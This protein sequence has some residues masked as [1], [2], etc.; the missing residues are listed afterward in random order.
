MNDPAQGR[1][2][3]FGLGYSARTLARRL[4][5][6]GWHVLGTAR[7]AGTCAGLQAAGIEAL[8][9]DGTAPL[10]PAKHP[11][12]SVTHVLSSVPPDVR[13]D[14][15]LR[16]HAEDLAGLSGLRWVGYLSTTGVY[17][18]RSGEWVDEDSTLRPTGMRGRRR[19]EAERAWLALGE[20]AGLAVH[21]FRLAGIYGPGRSA[22]E[23]LRQ[24]RAKRIRKPGQVFSRIHVDDLAETL[25]RSMAA[26]KAGRIYN[27]CDDK[28]AAPEDVVTFAARLLGMPPPPLVAFEDAD[29]SDMARSFYADNKRV[30]NDRIKRELGVVLRYADYEAGLNAILA[31]SLGN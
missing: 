3:C 7:T 9:F 23:A 11:L 18:D 31:A 22:L 6:R 15:V 8:P 25:L 24:G 28:P 12:A 4:G 1:L 19:A 20:K 29:L 21:V 26:P 27:V 5:A 10:A 13:G 16:H 2:F 30:R 17:G 14:P